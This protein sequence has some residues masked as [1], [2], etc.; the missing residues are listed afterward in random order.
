MSHDHIFR[1]LC[2]GFQPKSHTPQTQALAEKSAQ[3]LAAAGGRFHLDLLRNLKRIPPITAERN[4]AAMIQ[5]HGEG[6][7]LVVVGSIGAA[8]FS[9]D[10][11][12][13]D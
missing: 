5:N 2:F 10:F 9:E 1:S 3:D 12:G 4:S 7:C 8:V 6:C 13:S 11:C